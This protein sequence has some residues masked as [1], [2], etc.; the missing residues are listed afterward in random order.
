MIIPIT[1]TLT[2]IKL[3]ERR[4]CELCP[5]ALG[6]KRVFPNKKLFVV[7]TSIVGVDN[8]TVWELPSEAKEFIRLFD[9]SVRKYKPFT[10]E[11]EISEGIAAEWGYKLAE[12]TPD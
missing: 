7:P 4:E 1:V 12:V 10:F 11:V 6:L 2:D 3:G 8:K 5:I 9:N